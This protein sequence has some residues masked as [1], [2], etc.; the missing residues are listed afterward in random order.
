M[1]NMS[2]IEE[3]RNETVKSI[4]SLK[5]GENDE[6]SPASG[7]EEQFLKETDLE[8]DFLEDA[9]GSFGDV[10]SKTRKSIA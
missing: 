9:P 8:G 10:D 4:T 3:L 1:K 6:D 5:N 7:D 2:I